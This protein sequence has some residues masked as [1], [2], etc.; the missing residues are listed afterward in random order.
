MTGATHASEYVTDTVGLILRVERRKMGLTAKAIFDSAES[1]NFTIYVPAMAFAEILY[2]SEKGRIST[3]LQEVTDHLHRY[4]TYREYPMTL[5]VIQTA[6]EIIDVPELHD[7]LIAA[8]A[9]LLGLELL[10]NDGVMQG[11][12]FVRTLW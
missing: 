1:G 9:R 11:S 3:S 12:S 2:L 8:T 4:S 6:G 7:R 5:A 10:T